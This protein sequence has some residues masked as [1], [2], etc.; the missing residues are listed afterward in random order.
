MKLKRTL[1][2]LLSAAL[3]ISSLPIMAFAETQEDSVLANDAVDLLTET[4]WQANGGS[5]TLTDGVLDELKGTVGAGDGA[6]TNDYIH[7][8]LSGENAKGPGVIYQDSGVTLKEKTKYLL[9]VWLRSSAVVSSDPSV[10]VDGKSIIIDIGNRGNALS[11]VGQHTGFKTLTTNTADPNNDVFFISDEWQ[12]FNFVFET[13]AG[14]AINFAPGSTGINGLVFRYANRNAAHQA[15][16]DIDGLALYE[17]DGSYQPINGVNLFTATEN[18]RS[19]FAIQN[20][21]AHGDIKGTTTEIRCEEEYFHVAPTTGNNAEIYYDGLDLE[22]GK[23]MLSGDFKLADIDWDT[24]KGNRT[25]GKFFNTATVTAK[26]D[27]EVIGNG[28]LTADNDF[29]KLKFTFDLKTKL[30]DGVITLTLSDDIG[31]DF[32]NIELINTYSYPVNEN[33]AATNDEAIRSFTDD[34]EYLQFEQEDAL[35]YQFSYKAGSTLAAG[36]YKLSVTMRFNPE[37]YAATDYVNYINGTKSSNSRGCLVDNGIVVGINAGTHGSPIN[38][39]LIADAD[40]AVLTVTE[41]NKD[42]V[43]SDNGYALAIDDEWHTFDIKFTLKQEQTLE[44]FGA[45]SFFNNI[46]SD[47]T[48]P[49]QLLD[50]SLVNE[51][52]NEE[53]TKGMDSGYFGYRLN[54][55]SGYTGATTISEIF[56]Y[57]TTEGVGVSAIKP[58]GVSEYFVPGLYTVTG[59]VR[60]CDDDTTLTA[61]AGSSSVSQI[62]GTAWQDIELSLDLRETVPSDSFNIAFDCDYIDFDEL[63]ITG[64]EYNILESWGGPGGEALTKA[65]NDEYLQFKETDGEKYQFHYKAG[66]ALAAGEY[67][68]SV[69]MRFN[70]EEYAEK[71][72]A[73]YING[74]KASNPRGC[75]VDNGV[76]VGIN[77]LTHGY[78]ANNTLIASADNDVLKVNKFYKDGQPSDNAYALSIDDEWHTFDIEFTL[79]Q[80]QTLSQYGAIVFFV[81]IRS[82]FTIPVE[83][84]DITLI[85]TLTGDEY[86]QGMDTKYWGT[87]TYPTAGY[88]KGATLE[89]MLPYYTTNGMG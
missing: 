6:D 70:P 17:V 23:Y 56:P 52:T 35:K 5:L 51:T 11:M 66:N 26:L 78:P 72:Y 18:I 39:I 57:Y 47:F 55:A 61:S 67:K 63:T 19:Y 46:R 54:T 89:Q 1:S 79:K 28:T 68:L 86:T 16:F 33:W 58:I 15:P 41:F 43:A 69:T 75:L 40:N 3:A 24:F 48:I 71:D 8:S 14:S 53:Y 65:S 32:K 25:T 10:S 77:A 27:N 42:G 50:L 60:A 83:V 38:N 59:K 88:N 85:D 21:V 82:D 22:A 81:N 20:I 13:D 87:N 76:V 84:L 49:V 80:S 73:N 64:E 30:S 2:I 4:N 37:E 29:V 34:I 74:T 7:V 45:I 31:F 9:S 62:V 44:H 12:K 36:D